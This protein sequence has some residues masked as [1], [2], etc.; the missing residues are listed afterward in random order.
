MID[1]LLTV[2]VT[3]LVA[4]VGFGVAAFV[5]DRTAGLAVVEP[6]GVSRLLPQGRRATAADVRGVRFDIAVRGY[7]MAQV[8]AVLQRLSAELEQAQQRVAELERQC[9]T[10][11]PQA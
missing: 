4:G 11:V 6:D 5:L 8:D 7:R 9:R 2:L 3:A 1:L 10:S